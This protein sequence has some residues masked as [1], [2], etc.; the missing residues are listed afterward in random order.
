MGLSAA[1]TT[2]IAVSHCKGVYK[3]RKNVHVFRTTI[4]TGNEEKGRKRK[5]K[6]DRE[7]YEKTVNLRFI[8]FGQ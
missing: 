1:Y 6:C 7:K 8:L 5:K 3:T 2:V 4:R